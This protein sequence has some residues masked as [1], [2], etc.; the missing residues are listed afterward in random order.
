MCDREAQGDTLASGSA[1]AVPPLGR[2]LGRSLAGASPGI[3]SGAVGA[4]KAPLAGWGRGPDEWPIG[5]KA[6]DLWSVGQNPSFARAR[7]H[8]HANSVTHLW[9]VVNNTVAPVTGRPA[10]LR[11]QHHPHDG[12]ERYPSY[13][14]QWRL[15]QRTGSG[16]RPFP[17]TYFS[18]IP[19]VIFKFFPQG[20]H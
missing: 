9:A 13:P 17:Q 1:S 5:Y 3:L 10:R 18:E 6:A 4:F 15:M 2:D 14:T 19:P 16:G 11:N 20:P 12:Q 8:G 7:N